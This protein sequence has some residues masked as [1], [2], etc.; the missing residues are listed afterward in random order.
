LLVTGIVFTQR[1]R[2]YRLV[3]KQRQHAYT[4]IEQAQDARSLR[5]GLNL[6]AC[7]EGWPDQSSLTAWRQHWEQR[8]ETD[9]ALESLLNRLS[10][11]CYGHAADVAH[12]GDDELRELRAAI[13]QALRKPRRLK[14][15][16]RVVRYVDSRRLELFAGFKKQWSNDPL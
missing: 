2:D 1:W 8:Y 4:C 13:L 3:Q 11:Y 7:A 12:S 6:L 16:R 10:Y 14:K 5:N 9:P 15:R